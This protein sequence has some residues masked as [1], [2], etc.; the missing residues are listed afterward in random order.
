MATGTEHAVLIFSGL[1][2]FAIVIQPLARKIHIPFTAA[3]VYLGIGHPTGFPWIA[4]LLTGAL[5][6]RTLGILA[7]VPVLNRVTPIE[8]ISRPFQIVMLWGGLR[9][10]VTLALA[11]SLPTSLDYWLTNPVHCLWRSPVYAVYTGHDDCAPAA[12]LWSEQALKTTF[13]G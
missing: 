12:P 3:L 9:G 10:T 4:A 8:P 5:L 6:A 11:L 2:L 7:C 1:L 13:M